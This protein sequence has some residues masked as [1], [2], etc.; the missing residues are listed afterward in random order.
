MRCHVMLY[1]IPVAL[2]VIQ[3]KDLTNGRRKSV[4]VSPIETA[5]VSSDAKPLT[6][7]SRRELLPSRGENGGQ[8]PGLTFE[9]M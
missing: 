6:T 1:R 9:T 2:Q 3:K 5:L 7:A 8:R 4:A